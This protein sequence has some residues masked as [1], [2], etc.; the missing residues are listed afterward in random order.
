VN[1]V[2]ITII[3]SGSWGTALSVLLSKNK[4]TV[5]L[6]SYLQEEADAIIRDGEHKEF[7]A[8]VPIPKEIA[9]TAD[10]EQAMK[11]ASV[12]VCAVPSAHMRNTLKRF[13][14]L[15]NES[16]T[17][18]NVSKGFDDVKK[19]RLSQVIEEYAPNS[20]VA[21][22]SGP[23]HAEEVGRDTPTAIVAAAKDMSVARYVQDIFMR[24][25]FRV[26]T[27]KDI[28]G[29]ELGGALKNIIALVAG[30]SDGYGFGDNAKAAIMTRGVAEIARLGVAMGADQTTFSGLS[31]L[32]DLIV[33][34]T[35]VHSRNRRAGIL[36]GSGY[37]LEAALKEVRMV[38]EGVSAVKI[39]HHLSKV[40]NVE[41]PIVEEAIALLYKGKDTRDVVDDL[42]GRD[43]TS[44]NNSNYI[45]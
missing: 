44:E 23:T 43:K 45:F 40:H 42:M 38:V 26:Y 29:V 15:F 13:A 7:L 11:N 33:T 17:I 24:K 36:I 8:G 6:W 41:M 21:V 19:V 9:V 31:G 28:I 14:P 10:P 22:L 12:V 27:N 2:N 5:T 1:V 18:I 32:G 4:H 39:A 25:S 35:S 34:C 16:H 20:P 30:I 3:G 37:T